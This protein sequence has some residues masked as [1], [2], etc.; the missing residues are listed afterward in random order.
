MRRLL[1]VIATGSL[2]TSCAVIRPGEVGVKQKLGKLSDPKENGIIGYNPLVAKVIKLR[3][4]T[5]NIEVLI[6]LPSK[7][8]LTIKSEISILYNIDTKAAKKII[9]EIGLSYENIITAV[10]RSA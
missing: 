10:F 4:Q 3:T 2:L 8:G 1:L 5:T 6:N 9:N 7:E